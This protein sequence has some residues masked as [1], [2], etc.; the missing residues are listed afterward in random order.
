MLGV[1]R[2]SI[3]KL[4]K[5]KTIPTGDKF[6]KIFFLTNGKVKPNDIL[7]IEQWKEELN[8]NGEKTK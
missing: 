8:N 6:K 7:P 2:I 4:I 3:H 1:S 5:Y